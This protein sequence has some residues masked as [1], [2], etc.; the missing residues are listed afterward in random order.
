MKFSRRDFL[1]TV[2]TTLTSWGMIG[3]NFAL[4]PLTATGVSLNPSR[5]LALLV[6]I[7]QYSEGDS[8]KGCKT[9]V[10]LQQNLLIHRL[11]F[12]PTDII[13][14]INRQATRENILMTFQ[15]HLMAQAGNNDLVIFHFSG[16]GRQVRLNRD[17]PEV[18]NSLIAYDTIKPD[19]NLVKDI[20][21]DTISKLAQSLKTSKYILCFDTGFVSTSAA[22]AN[23]FSCRGYTSSFNTIIDSEE[24]TFN[25]NLSKNNLPK[26]SKLSQNKSASG[27]ILSPS[28]ESIVSEIQSENFSVGLFT[29]FLTQ[30]LW[31]TLTPQDSLNTLKKVA[32]PIALASNNRENITLSK[33][34]NIETYFPL[35][36]KKGEGIISK[37]ISPN[38][39]EIELV[40][41]PLLVLLNYGVNSYFVGKSK[42]EENIT[43]QLNSLQGNKGKGILINTPFDLIEENTI[44]QES[45]RILRRSIGLTIALNN[46]LEKIEK[47]DATSALS[48]LNTIES[49]INVGDNFSDCILGKFKNQNN[50]IEG[51]SLFS[52]VGVLYTN[53]I[54]KIPNEAVSAA[55]KRLTPSLKVALF[56]KLLHLTFNQASSNLPLNVNLEIKHNSETFVT[57]Q[58]TNASKQKQ[59]NHQGNIKEN[60]LITIPLGSQFTL[61]IDN[62]NN[63]DLYYLLLGI[64]SSRHGI[65]YYSPY[66]SMMTAKTTI[67][68]PE[69]ASP[70]KWVINGEKGVGEFIL[71]CSKSPFNE[72]LNQL[73]NTGN[74]NL[75]NEQII[76]LDNPVMVAKSILQDLHLGSNIKPNMVTNFN[77][78]Y[79]LDLNNWV[80]FNFVYEIV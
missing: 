62:E 23:P 74:I 6:G 51:Y 27:L 21:V 40:G 64:N 57:R 44:L 20:L 16:Y 68:I 28:Q 5:K 39:V 75:D 61:T 9:D 1:Q 47:V 63:H 46:T 48:A 33:I 22:I 26:I 31:E 41:L 79:A 69:N 30:S 18:V 56:Q 11:G 78:V 65:I 14:L 36:D 70:L 15:Q 42:N 7:N 53:T 54:A 45:I 24:L 32:S 10:E 76:F 3:G 12:L 35:N 29:Y 13:T 66:A 50:A 59:S 25:Q 19:N 58:Q 49:V 38:L 8:L 80:T 73:F 55:V 71:I 67:A 34:K 37:K 43:I 52:C 4:S 17:N 77:D 2:V 60:L 72:T